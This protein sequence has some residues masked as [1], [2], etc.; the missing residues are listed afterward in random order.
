MKRALLAACVAS[1]LAPAA[2]HAYN[3]PAAGRP[4]IHPAVVRIVAPGRGSTSYGSGT[5][6]ATNEHHGL[7][8]TN[9]HVVNEATEPVTVL[10]PDGFQSSGKVQK[11]DRTWDLAAV[12]VWKPGNVQ[13]VPMANS[14]PRP[15]EMLTIAG[16]G[17]GAYR[18]VSGPCTQYVA[19]GIRQPYEMVELAASARQ[20]DS[21]G[22]IF[23]SRGEMAGVLFGEGGGRTSGS[24]CGRVRYFLADILPTGEQ[25]RA[26]T[27]AAKPS[28]PNPPPAQ[29]PPQLAYQPPRAVQSTPPQ[30]PAPVITTVPAPALRPSIE[31]P[32]AQSARQSGLQPNVDLSPRSQYIGW[33][34]LAGETR[35]EQVK[36]FL[37]ALGALAVVIHTLRWIAK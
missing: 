26:A 24:Y 6:V 7:V 27:I 2:A 33:Q 25:N 8:L 9:W 14:A 12:V 15:G 20:G 17:S 28:L 23:N 16:Y 18:A 34:E 1:V 3:S 29:E 31:Q 36:T 5:L 10:F 37:A 32:L 13:P 21:G 19:P 11:I 35:G 30:T 4:N 22:P